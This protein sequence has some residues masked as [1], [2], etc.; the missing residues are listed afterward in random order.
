MW[1]HY[2]HLHT[3]FCVFSSV[4]QTNYEVRMSFCLILT[5]WV[6]GCY[7][8]R[9][10]LQLSWAQNVET[11]NS[12]ADQNKIDIE[13]IKGNSKIFLRKVFCLFSGSYN[14]NYHSKRGGPAQLKQKWFLQEKEVVWMV[15]NCENLSRNFITA[16]KKD[17]RQLASIGD[18][19]KW[20]PYVLQTH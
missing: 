13:D 17:H 9:S 10:E 11:E 16:G 3:K 1:Y 8:V 2:Q 20:Q 6:P 4:I 12:K 19:V 14:S 15:K 5:F 18:S 7:M